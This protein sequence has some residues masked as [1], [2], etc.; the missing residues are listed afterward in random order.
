MDVKY[1]EFE[2]DFV[3]EKMRCIPM[4]VRFKLDACGI[5][6]KL[7]EWSRMNQ[8]ERQLLAEMPIGTNDELLT[9]RNYL[10][11]LVFAKTGSQATALAD[12][13]DSWAISD[14]IPDNL[15]AKLNQ[16]N[17]SISLEKWKRLTDLQRFALIKLAQ[18]S[19]ENK[20]LPR[21]LKEFEVL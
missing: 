18:S 12:R 1:F 21:A 19:Q 11:G 5:K 6:L 8:D 14:K 10:D 2:N 20:N 7:T 15:I 13:N 17:W 4:V 3:E 9:Y 16:L